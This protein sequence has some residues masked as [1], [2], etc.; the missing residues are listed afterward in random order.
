M[1]EDK[2]IIVKIVASKYL[3]LTFIKLQI[4]HFDFVVQKWL[5]NFDPLVSLVLRGGP[6]FDPV[7]YVKE[8]SHVKH[9]HANLILIHPISLRN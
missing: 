5:F 2:I 6:N 1:N 4:I 7:K 8:V 9:M 3:K